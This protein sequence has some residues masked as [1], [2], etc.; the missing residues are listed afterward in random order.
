M[1]KMPY[2]PGP[3]VEPVLSPVPHGEPEPQPNGWRA[4]LPELAGSLVTLR[5]LRTGDATS[6]FAAMMNDEV[7]RFISPPPTT[8]N[9]FERFIRWTRRQRAAGQSICFAIVERGSDVAIGVFQVRSLDRD[10]VHGR[11]G[12]CDRVRVLG[13]GACS[14]MAHGWPSPSR[15]MSSASTGWKR[16]PRS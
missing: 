6:L 4:G 11:M 5:E 7:T 16:A 14:W 9:G 12:L 15:S 8:V 13:H 2:Q 1:E 3:D 10:F